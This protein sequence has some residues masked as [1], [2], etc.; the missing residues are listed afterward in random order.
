MV[1]IEGLREEE[2][3]VRGHASPSDSDLPNVAPAAALLL[4]DATCFGLRLVL[5]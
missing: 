4:F 3:T 1:K 2:S 5:L